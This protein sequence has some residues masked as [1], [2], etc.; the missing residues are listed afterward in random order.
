M[1]LGRTHPQ[2]AESPAETPA[3]SILFVGDMGR[4]S[5]AAM[6][7]RALSELGHA[8]RAVGSEPNDP[9]GERHYPADLPW[10]VCAKFGLPPDRAGVNAALVSALDERSY[11][12][13]WV[14]KSLALRT[15]TLL[16]ARRTQPKMQLVF[17]SEDDMF[18]R[19]NQSLWFR[20][21]LPLYDV[22]FTHKS[23]NADPGELPALG[24]RRVVMVDKCF[25]RHLHRPVATTP[26]DR[27]ALGSPVGFAGTFERERAQSMLALAEAG[28]GVRV[29]GNGWSAW[30]GR[31]PLLAVEGCD[32]AVERYVRAISATDVNLGF[33]RV[34]NRDLQTDRSVEIPACGG[35][36][37]AQRTDEHRRLFEEGAEAEFFGSQD[38]LLAKVRHYLAHPDERRRIA[39]AGRARCLAG[40]AFHDRLRDLLRIVRESRAPSP[41]EEAA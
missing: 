14:S 32:L 34:Q 9:S 15:Q 18:A 29:W 12:V 11:D 10:R 2:R 33:L 4:S 40:Y 28:V 23:Y 35:F 16:R 36:L 3:L 20:R 26:E 30:R 27:A 19:H 37:L 17:H 22:V 31:H 21:S 41:H 38:E 1:R 25:D 13:L 39:A 5:R 6:L 7:A 24:A 8:V